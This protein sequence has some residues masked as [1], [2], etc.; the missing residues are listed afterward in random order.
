MIDDNEKILIYT[1][2]SSRGNPGQ[3]G[4]GCIIFV[5]NRDGDRNVSV[6]ELGGRVGNTTNNR[7]EIT[8][9][10]EA[11]RFLVRKGCLDKKKEARIFS[12]SHYLMN[13][14]TKW[15]FGW[16]KNDWISSQKTNVLNRELW[17]ELFSLTSG[18]SINWEYV[19]GH[20]GN[21]LNER[22]DEI[23][24]S[25]ADGKSAELYSG[26]KANYPFI[27]GKSGVEATHDGK[28]WYVSVVGGKIERHDSWTECEKRIGGVSGARFKK[29]KS[30]FEER[31][32]LK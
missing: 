7:M 10:I 12:D 29:V 11:L 17:Q 28:S 5:P 9:A 21:I 1:D 14:I 24:T 31:D 13:G 32:F 2:G 6:Y 3:G 30:E 18:R 27:R 16:I 25:H 22:C 8:A 19:K 26:E 23:A 4:W 20:D 15:I